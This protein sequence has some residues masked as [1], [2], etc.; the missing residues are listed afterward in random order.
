MPHTLVT[1][2]NSFVAPHI[3][4]ELIA[5]GHTVTGSVRRESAGQS[6][7]KEHP[8][9]S[10]KLDF[11]VI[12]DYSDQDALDTVFRNHKFDHVVH[13][14]APMPGN[15]ELVDYDRD[16]LRPSVDSNLTLL[17]AAK[18]Y[19]PTLKSI[20]VTGSVNSITTGAVEDNKAREYTNESWND[21]TPES[22]RELKSDFISYCSSKKESELAL[23]EFVKSEKPNF[24]VTVLLPALIF[25]PPLQPLTDLKNL[26]LSVGL[27]YRYFNGSFDELPNTHSAIFPSYVDVRDLA[28]AHVRAL[29]TPEAANK[30]FLIGGEPLTSSLI[31][32]TLRTLSD[33]GVLPS[34]FKNRLPKDTGKDT[35]LSL[36]RIRAEEGNKVFKLNL[37]NAEETFGDLA[38]KVLELEKKQGI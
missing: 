26:N 33:K 19:A 11:I 4:N 36:P 17:K 12:Q 25:G 29:T 32:N 9:W 35:D 14:A 21:I 16:F 23:W 22:A 20:A 1:G 3:I 28:S 2:A 18:A 24:S 5:E 38:K 37:R 31:V 27:V 8:E 15:P 7:L 13:V 6:I 34:D 30:R 10:G